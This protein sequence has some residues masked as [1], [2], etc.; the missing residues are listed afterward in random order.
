[1]FNP[2]QYPHFQGADVFIL[3]P[4]GDTWNLHSTTLSSASTIFSEFLNINP[5]ANI[6]PKQREDGKTIKW[7]FHMKPDAKGRFVDFE[8]VVRFPLYHA[9]SIF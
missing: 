3:A 6:T 7:R 8:F 5:P 9:V 2:A 4:T 1:M